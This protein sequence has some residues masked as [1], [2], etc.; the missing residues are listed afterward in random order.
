MLHSKLPTAHAHTPSRT[1]LPWHSLALRQHGLGSVQSSSLWSCTSRRS[2]HRRSNSSSMQIQHS[3]LALAQ[4]AAAEVSI[5]PSGNDRQIGSSA[6]GGL[7]GGS[8]PEAGS[9]Q[10]A[11]QDITKLP[12][13]QADGSG[14]RLPPT[15]PITWTFMITYLLFMLVVPII[16]LVVRLPGPHVGLRARLRARA[17]S[18]SCKVACPDTVHACL[19]P[20]DEG[21]SDA[22][23]CL[24][25]TRL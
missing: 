15:A 7:H 14:F 5:L 23:K 6:A 3:R 8:S 17:T 4:A 10:A 25:G 11:G 12:R 19:R 18:S 16:A 21:S 9:K 2:S 20:A 24:C 1:V 22:R 13:L